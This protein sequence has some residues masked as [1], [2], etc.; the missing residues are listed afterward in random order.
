MSKTTPTRT[1]CKYSRPLPY[2]NPKCRTHRHWKFTLHHCT[3]R[4]PHSFGLNLGASAD[5]SVDD[6]SL[7]GSHTSVYTTVCKYTQPEHHVPRHPADSGVNKKFTETKLM[8]QKPISSVHG[9]GFRT[10]AKMLFQLK[11]DLWFG[12]SI[13]Y[14]L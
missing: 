1:Y 2:C 10:E 7:T 8:G 12:L 14:S 9:Y 6:F 5:G 3:T 11:H 4:P 13:F